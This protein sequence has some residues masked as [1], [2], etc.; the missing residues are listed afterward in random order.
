ML[1]TTMEC[2]HRYTLQVIEKIQSY[3]ILVNKQYF[4]IVELIMFSNINSFSTKLSCDNFLAEIELSSIDIFISNRM[5]SLKKKK[6]VSYI[7]IIEISFLFIVLTLC[8]HTFS[9]CLLT[10]S[11]VT[12]LILCLYIYTYSNNLIILKSIYL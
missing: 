12:N 9:F 6:F 2:F 11:Y 1:L 3:F 10:L 8:F 5:Y 7:V 4:L